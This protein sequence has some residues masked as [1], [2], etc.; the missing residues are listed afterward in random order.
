MDGK[1]WVQL[2]MQGAFSSAGA[3]EMLGGEAMLAETYRK[4]LVGLET[5]LFLGPVAESGLK[6]QDVKLYNDMTPVSVRPQTRFCFA[7]YHI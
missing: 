6:K 1:H 4:H 3:A 7:C 5:H 2:C